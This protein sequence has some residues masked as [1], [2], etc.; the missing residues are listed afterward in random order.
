MSL[1]R[2]LS[3]ALTLTDEV[4]LL[5]AVSGVD[6]PYESDVLYSKWGPSVAAPLG[7]TLPAIVAVVWPT[8]LREPPETPGGAE[9]LRAGGDGERQGERSRD[10]QRGQ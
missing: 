10:Q 8:P 2:L 6:R 9:V 7:S 1:V 4:L 5:A 3:D